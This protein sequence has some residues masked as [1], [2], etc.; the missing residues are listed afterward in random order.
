MNN[1]AVGFPLAPLQKQIET[2]PHP[3]R[4]VGNAN[5]FKL[6]QHHSYMRRRYWVRVSKL[7]K[8]W[9]GCQHKLAANNSS[10]SC[11]ARSTATLSRDQIIATILR[12]DKICT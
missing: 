9:K 7:E 8:E 2:A 6:F 10:L 3:Q 5:I 11:E 4:Q 12:V 1:S